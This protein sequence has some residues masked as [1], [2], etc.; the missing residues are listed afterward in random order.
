MELPDYSKDRL[1][2]PNISKVQAQLGRIATF[3]HVFLSPS[4]PAVVH[5]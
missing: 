3:D 5:I 1:L 4:I 2:I